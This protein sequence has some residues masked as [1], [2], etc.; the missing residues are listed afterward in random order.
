[1]D[2]DFEISDDVIDGLPVVSVAG[3]IDVATAP[4]LR[5]RVEGRISERSPT[6]VVDLQRV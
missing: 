1:M 5:S 4:A 2:L 6:V 3:E